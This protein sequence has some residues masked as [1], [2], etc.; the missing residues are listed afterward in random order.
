[1]TSLELDILVLEKVG[2]SIEIF[3]E[4]VSLIEAL[5]FLEKLNILFKASIIKNH[6]LPST[7]HT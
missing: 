4:G 1:M 5:I 6:H 2:L 3:E 7:F